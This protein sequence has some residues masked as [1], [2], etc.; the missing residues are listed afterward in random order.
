MEVDVQWF[1]RGKAAMDLRGLKEG[2]SR[3]KW[4]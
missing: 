1:I 2:F 3:W 4:W